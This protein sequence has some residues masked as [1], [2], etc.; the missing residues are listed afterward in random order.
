MELTAQYTKGFNGH[1]INALAGY[2][3]NKYN[4][5]E[6]FMDNYD[7]PSDDY[8]YNSMN[9]GNALKLGKATEKSKQTENKLVSYFGRINYNYNNRYFLSASVRHEG[10]SKFGADHKWGTF[11][12]VSV[13]WNMKGESFLKA[14]DFLSVLKLRGGYGITGTV[15]TDPYMSLNKL[16]LGGYGYYNGEWVNLLRPD[17]NSN[18]D[19]R[20]EK[21]KELNL[22]LDFGFFDDRISGS[23][24]YYNRKTVDLIW[25]YTVAVPPYVSSSIRANAGS[26]RNKGL[27]VTLNVIPVQTKNFV[28]SSDINFSTNKSKLI[29]FSNDKFIAGTYSDQ[30]MLLAPI[31][32]S[33]HRLEVGEPLGNFYG[34]KSIDIDDDGH[35]IIEGAD[36]KPKPIAEQQATDKKVLGNALPKWYLNWNNSLSYKQFDMNITMRGAF[37][38]QILNTPEMYYAAPVALGNGNTLA[39]AFDKVYDKR[40]LANDQSLQYVS[41]YVQDGDYW[42]IDN[43]T[44][45]Y[46]PALKRVSWIK[47]LRVYASVS[48][49]AT[50]T[51][52]SG[53]DPEVS[54]SGLTP[55]IDDKLRY[56]AART[57]TFGVNLNF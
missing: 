37:G 26:I 52:Y 30:G 34:Y 48:N 8:T 18:P 1:N 19:L 6:A 17:G 7:F 5:Q 16:N 35:W 44:L 39:K 43:L 21:K 10:S 29:S 24:D 33:T 49:L 47:K 45:G 40:P 32:Q 23:I 46:T 4:Y 3:W 27:E 25:D 36:G 54:V 31:Q 57:Y 38:F 28:W 12:A 51:G 9:Q 55:G 50:I 22:G 15:P 2:S 11:P 41:Y 13:G 53:I 14:V 56:P 20:W 42:K